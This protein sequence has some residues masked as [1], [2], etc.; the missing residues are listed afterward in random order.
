LK[1]C[2]S[3]RMRASERQRSMCRC[4]CKVWVRCGRVQG[5]GFRVQGSGRTSE[6]QRS[7]SV[8]FESRTRARANRF[9]AG[10]SPHLLA[11]RRQRQACARC[12][13]GRSAAR[14]RGRWTSRARAPEDETHSGTVP[15]SR[16]SRAC[17]RATPGLPTPP[18]SAALHLPREQLCK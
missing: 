16:L 15:E 3:S 12:Q 5:L 8:P 14:R 6:P 13:R 17:P 18:S 7:T 10:T 11:G 9:Q 4:G 1:M 2:A